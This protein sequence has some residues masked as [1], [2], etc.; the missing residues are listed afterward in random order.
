MTLTAQDLTE[1]A[2]RALNENNLEAA[3]FLIANALKGNPEPASAQ[4]DQQKTDLAICHYLSGF[5]GSEVRF[6]E[7]ANHLKAKYPQQLD[8]D[9]VEGENRPKWRHYISKGLDRLR[10]EDLLTRGAL[11]TSHVVPMGFTANFDH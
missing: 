8:Q 7:I 5:E 10:D 2:Q 4:L 6:S 3:K 1:L 9:W 11:R